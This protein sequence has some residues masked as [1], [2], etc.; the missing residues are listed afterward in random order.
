MT[1][2]VKPTS[3]CGR[4]LAVLSDGQPHTTRDLYRRCGGMVLHSRISDLRA[5][6]YRIEC[7]HIAGKG[8]GAGAYRY[9]WLDAP[10]KAVN[11]ARP[12]L[13]DKRIAEYDYRQRYRFYQPGMG[14]EDQVWVGCAGAETLGGLGVMLAQF[15]EEE[16]IDPRQPLGI[17]D[18][19]PWATGEPGK[20]LALPYG[21]AR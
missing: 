1:A 8:T 5:K 2:D 4:V 6:G 10:G 12:A 21:G 7:Q 16:E 11:G 14:D 9:Q 3:H 19:R 20:W 15:I 17:M 18:T 13:R